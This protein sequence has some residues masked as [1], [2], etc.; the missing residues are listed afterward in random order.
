M[1]S[2]PNCLTPCLLYNKSLML[3]PVWS[4]SATWSKCHREVWWKEQRWDE[5]KV[6][7]LDTS[8]SS[9]GT[10][11][12][13]CCGWSLSQ[14][15]MWPRSRGSFILDRNQRCTT[16]GDTDW[17]TTPRIKCMTSECFGLGVHCVLLDRISTLIISSGFSPDQSHGSHWG[18][19]VRGQMTFSSL[20]NNKFT[21][22]LRL[23]WF[24]VGLGLM[25]SANTTT[26]N[27]LLLMAD[28]AKITVRFTG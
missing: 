10:H 14:D 21:T 11:I 7:M 28:T 24:P 25:F 22:T 12:N 17:P 8:F 4:S 27:Y 6:L 5:E 9:V 20:A 3:R 23:F 15:R 13:T 2:N 19:C 1:H 26:N 16:V 18:V